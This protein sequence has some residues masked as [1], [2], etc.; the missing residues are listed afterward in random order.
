[1]DEFLR[2]VRFGFRTLANNPASTL[3]AVVALSLGIGANTAIFSVVSALLIRPLPYP[4]PDRI[5]VVWQ[6]K[7][8]KGMRQQ[9]VSALDYQDYAREQ[10]V[11]DRFGVL[12]SQPSVLTGGD[13]PERIETASVSRDVLDL[14]GAKTILGRLFDSAEQQPGK[15]HVVVLTEGLWRRRFGGE[16]SILGKALILDGAS[17]VVVG[18]VPASMQLPD[19]PCELWMP[20]T[21]DLKDLA[22]GRRAFRFLKVL[23][24]L[25]PGVSVERAEGDMGAIAHRLAGQY[26]DT[27]A[28]YGTEIIPLSEQLIGDI[29]PTLWALS[30]AVGMVLLIACANVANLL[31]ARA[32]GREK[33]IAVRTTLGARPIRLI[34]QLLTESLLLALTSGVVGLFIAYSGVLMLSR[35]GGASI[36]RGGE[37]S[38]DWR[39]LAFTV[40]VSA[41]TG[42][43]FG[44]APAIS[45]IRTDLNSVLKTT[46]RSNTGNR[47]RARMRNIL[48]VSEIALCLTLL[49]GAGLLIRSFARLQHVNPGFRT[50]HVLTMQLSLPESRY[51]GLKVAQFYQRLLDRV[52]TLPGVQSAGISRYLPL[53]GA[54]ASLNF[55]ME[56]R[57]PVAPTDQPRAKYRAVSPEYFTALGI[58]LIRGRYFDPSD[59]QDTAGVVLINEAMAKRHWPTE[60]P[61]GKRIRPGIEEHKWFNVVGVVGDVKHSGLDAPSNEEM[62]YHYLQAPVELMSFLEGTMTLVVRTSGDPGAMTAAIRNEVRAV[63]G[64]QPV[65]NVK[66]I[67]DVVSGSIARPRFRTFLLSIF[68]A[69][70]LILAAVGL[71][72]LIAY[73][74]TQR[75]NELG[76]RS[77]LG[78]QPGEI[79]AMVLGEGARLAAIGITLG[80][81]LA[82]MATRLLSKLLFGIDS[83]DPITFAVTIT[84]TAFVSLFATY[85]PA[86][87]AAKLDPIAALRHE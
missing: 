37:I 4:D 72:G 16:R 65:F 61:I 5:V 53:S 34:R 15:N 20:Y 33:E 40:V 38:I 8:S 42:I 28:G 50:D 9:R 25:R 12:R 49:V 62:Y 79:L 81:I 54:D 18:V 84:L 2:D 48:V 67:N 63:D 80:I 19:T 24:H 51:T 85:V 57:P 44:L 22:P 52:R 55:V 7:L 14:L 58:P 11:F 70:A 78:A 13:L 77:A 82:L 1:M 27:N 41:A 64:D 87:R 74:V 56:S 23:G 71:Y 6:N 35:L 45:T 69:L 76:V 75:T 26:P 59:G 30:A 3:V 10:Q 32:G 46:G 39:V 47:S 86:R 66:T 31:L 60:D 17:Y 36:P 83:L 21:P 68:A 43:I 73:S 29:R